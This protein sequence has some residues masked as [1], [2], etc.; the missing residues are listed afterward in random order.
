[1]TSPSVRCA[2]YT[3]KSSDEGLEQSFNSLDAQR[4]ACEAYVKSQVGE[5]WK[6]LKTAYDDGGF[7]GGSMDRP[8]LKLLLADI[9]AGLIDVVVVYKVDRLT[10]SLMDFAKIVDNFDA[11]GVSFVSV[12]QAFNTTTSMGRLTLNVLLSFAQFEREVTSERIRDKIAASKAKGMWM[13]GSLPLGYDGPSDPNGVRALVVNPK[14]A[15]VVKLIFRRYLEIGNARSL[16]D[17]LN[18]TGLRSKAWVARDGRTMGDKPF[19]RGSLFHLLKN[20][21]YLG[22]TVHLKTSY[23][24]LHPGIVDQGLFDAVQDRL[25]SQTRLHE[26][27]PMRGSSAMLKGLIFDAEGIGMAATFTAK[28]GGRLYRYY[29]SPTWVDG[30][31]RNP[32]P[33]TIRRV[34]GTLVER[35]VRGVL[36]LLAARPE[37]PPLVRVEVHSA[38][39]QIVLRRALFFRRQGDPGAE[40]RTLQDRLG[41][42]G[43]LTPEP[44]D[45]E[46]IRVI[47][48]GRVTRPGERVRFEGPWDRKPRPPGLTRSSSRPFGEAM[49]SWPRWEVS[50]AGLRPWPPTADPRLPMTEPWSVWR[51]SPPTFRP[52]SWRVGSP[53]P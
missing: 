39:L 34:S 1:V 6:A 14:E 47:L 9:A 36:D 43:Y 44:G 41:D 46:L 49:R 5:G 29:V 27:R 32:S 51:S 11:Q 10:R 37:D 25:A 4:E 8:G 53:L 40:I 12:T 21:T 7:S 13:G 35:Q 17:W 18:D 23:P 19:N 2:I 16:R 50:S 31:P 30:G 22:E 26:T 52:K 15:E 33:D 45:P 42:A 28:S 3:R 48:E 24:G 20:R 38:T